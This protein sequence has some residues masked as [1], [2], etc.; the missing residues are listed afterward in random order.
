MSRT[1]K[2]QMQIHF[3]VLLWGFTAILGRMISLPALPLVFW[4]MSTV[5]IALACVPRVWRACSEL[6]PRTLAAFAGVGALLGLHWLTFYLSIKASNASV[7]ATCMALAPV[8]LAFIEPL[9]T[10]RRFD[11][12][13]AVLGVAAVAGVATVLGGIPAGMRLGVAI[14]ALS[15]VIVAVF[16]ALNKR[17]ILRA[18]AL[19]VTAVEIGAGAL[20][21]AVLA[22]LVPHEGPAFPIPGGRDAV[23]LAILALGCTLLPY[24]LHLVALRELSAFWVALATNL[25]PVYSILLAIPL[26]GEHHQLTPRFYLGVS[27]IVVAV[28]AY[29]LL[30]AGTRRA[31]AHPDPPRLA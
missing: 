16:G 1:T 22:P 26:L 10:G 7:G 23:L 9:I 2:A 4:R 14:G 28:V 31:R 18:D 5:A 17:L 12:R 6:P 15:S 3:C 21:M 11:P 25:E 24:W 29:P 8:F 30:M 19:S 27:I 20:L 13:D